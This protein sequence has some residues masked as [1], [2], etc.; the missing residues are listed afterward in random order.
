MCPGPSQVL[1]R[2]KGSVTWSPQCPE[3]AGLSNSLQRFADHRQET[4]FPVKLG[5]WDSEKVP[6]RP[7][8]TWDPRA[9]PGM[10]PQGLRLT[11]GLFPQ[12]FR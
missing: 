3:E 7:M 10:H 4:G 1:S 9:Q 11:R 5:P 8:C 2:P 6:A 12:F